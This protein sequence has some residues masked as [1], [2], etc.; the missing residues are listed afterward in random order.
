MTAPVRRVRFAWV[1]ISFC[2]WVALIGGRLV[3]LQVVRHSEW[4]DRAK[5]QQNSALELAP[6]RGVLYDRN[7]RELAMTVQVDS[8]LRFRPNWARTRPRRR[9]CWLS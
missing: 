6:Q 4:V 1:A 8:I 3:W 9:R 2:L 7:L 5:R